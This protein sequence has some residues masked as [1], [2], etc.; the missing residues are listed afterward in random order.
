MKS[1][2]ILNE[3]FLLQNKEKQKVSLRFFKTGPGEY[4][5]GDHF[6]GITVPVLRTI[7][8]KYSEIDFKELQILIKSQWHEARALVLFILVL[9][10]KKAVKMNEVNEITKIFNFYFKNKAF[11]NNW[12]LV[13]LSA[14]YISGHYFYHVSNLKLEILVN[15]KKLWERRIAIISMLY[16]IRE[17]EFKLPL[18][19]IKQRLYDE[20]DLIHKACGWML[21]ELG[22]KD[23]AI[24]KKFLNQEAATMPRT[25]LRYSIEKLSVKDKTKYMLMGKN[26]K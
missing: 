15:S 8:K 23:E 3:L 4:G 19:I 13:D 17:N 1:S 16:Y 7:S 18:A 5:E 10:Y 26:V 14:P 6:L 22:K 9:K 20:E 12:D 25:T 21:R 2:N 24:L 11:V